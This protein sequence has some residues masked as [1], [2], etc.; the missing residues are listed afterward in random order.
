MQTQQSG[1]NARTR[2]W[3]P[4]AALAMMVAAAA[5]AD[6]VTS[7]TPPDGAG[8]R[9]G[10]NA[11][12]TGTVVTPAGRLPRPCVQEVPNGAYVG[13]GGQVKRRDGSVY[14]LSQCESAQTGLSGLQ[15]PVN[16]GWIE[17]AHYNPGG[18]FHQITARWRVPY[19]PMGAYSGTQNVYFSFP[20]LQSAS[21]II[22]PVIQYGDNGAF[23]GTYWTAASWH[24]NSGSNCTHSTPINISYGD[25]IAGSVAASG[26]FGGYCT[27]T[28][29]T[30]DVTT[31][32][33]TT[34]SVY[35]TESY[36]D[37]VGGAVEVY[38]LTSCSQYPYDGVSYS[39]IQLYDSSNTLVTPL[40]WASMASSPSPSCS[41]GM[42]STSSTVSLTHNPAP[43]I[44]SS[45]STS[46][47]PAVQYT[48]NT[49]TINGSGFNTSN[50]VVQLVGSASS[51]CPTA[52]T[53]TSFTTKT[54]TQLVLYPVS[55][56]IAGTYTVY[57]RNGA[58]GN[59]GG[60]QTVTF[61]PI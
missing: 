7:V 42:T 21:Y 43:P 31:S 37:A 53:P 6:T 33:S 3:M 16:N 56:S 58:G 34:Y 23:G 15:A 52:C 38:G 51:S 41:F 14:Q 19:G 20:G 8:G 40:W 54:S 2:R 49:L 29:T 26:C 18:N 30:T 24:C 12:D 32:T 17:S 5:C 27:W 22:Q 60:G 61:R 47:S 59:P 48:P 46:P 39:Q 9:P 44:V 28:I 36:F 50:V 1:T 11:T 35:D 4:A 10:A 55:L 45:V 25:S 57:V 13:R